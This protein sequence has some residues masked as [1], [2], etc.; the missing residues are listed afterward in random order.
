MEDSEEVLNYVHEDVPKKTLKY[1]FFFLTYKEIL[2]E[3][4]EN[5][6]MENFHYQKDIFPHNF[7]A[8]K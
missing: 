8:N 6:V 1:I 7:F 4:L 2:K 3:K 5:L